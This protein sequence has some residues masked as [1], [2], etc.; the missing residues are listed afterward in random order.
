MKRTRFWV[1]AAVIGGVYAV[2]TVVLAPISYGPM[3]VRVSELLTVLP[4]F[5]PAAVPGLFAGCII[6][7]LM[8]PYGVVDLIFGSAASLIAAVL[9]YALRSRPLLVP[10]PP[11]LI[12]GVII[13][14]MLY[15]VYGV[16]I[17]LIPCMLWVALGQFISCYLLGYPF[18]KYME[19]HRKVFDR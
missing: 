10:M 5:T 19:R 11:V 4:Y 13:G 17:G 2:L 12:N 8:S 9:S 6:A 1:Q 7:N 14:S 18:L 3:Q 16:D 15:F